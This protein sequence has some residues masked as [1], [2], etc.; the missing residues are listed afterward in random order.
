MIV[1][2]CPGIVTVSAT[3]LLGNAS[4]VLVE[5][6]VDLRVRGS[7]VEAGVARLQI[8]E[9]LGELVRGGEEAIRDLMLR[10]RCRA[11]GHCRGRIERIVRTPLGR[12][13]ILQLVAPHREDLRNDVCGEYS[14]CLSRFSLCIHLLRQDTL[15]CGHDGSHWPFHQWPPSKN[16]TDWRHVPNLSRGKT[17][18]PN[19]AV[20]RI[21][22]GVEHLS[23]TGLLNLDGGVPES[24]VFLLH[25]LTSYCCGTPASG[26]FL[27]PKSG[28]PGAVSA[29]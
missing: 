3:A 16:Y 21:G 27:A 5:C 18:V 12:P 2:E 1:R 26:T 24:L 10:R 25:R 15:G 6:F 4:V 8:D 13:R 29:A 14:I 28:Q 23:V 17:I 22:R 11:V 9:A 20:V 19:A 7:G